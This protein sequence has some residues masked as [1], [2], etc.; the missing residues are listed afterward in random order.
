MEENKRQEIKTLMLSKWD[1]PK[2]ELCNEIMNGYIFGP[3]SNNEHYLI[4][5]I[6]A[7]YDMVYLEQNPIIENPVIENPESFPI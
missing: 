3:Y 6:N 7:I 1:M 5:E 4:D 2:K